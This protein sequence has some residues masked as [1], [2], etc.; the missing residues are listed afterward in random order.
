M[1]EALE[2]LRAHLFGPVWSPNCLAK[3]GMLCTPAKLV[4]SYPNTRLSR[5]VSRQVRKRVT[6]IFLKVLR[7]LA[8][9]VV[10]VAAMSVDG[11]EAMSL[12]Q[13]L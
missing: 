12:E 2:A 8:T 10:F 7:K 5:A 4:V 3:D 11:E 9:A 13:L 1:K 6:V